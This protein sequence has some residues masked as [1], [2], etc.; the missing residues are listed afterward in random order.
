[1]LRDLITKWQGALMQPD[2]GG[3]L[4]LREEVKRVRLHAIM[5]PPDDWVPPSTDEGVS[6]GGEG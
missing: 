6:D 1:M 3:S 4:S 2:M 5:E